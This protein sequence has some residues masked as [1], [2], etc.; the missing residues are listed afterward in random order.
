MRIHD[1]FHPYFDDVKECC[2]ELWCLFFGD[3]EKET[4]E[5]VSHDEMCKVLQRTLHGVT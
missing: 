3:M 1:Y 2:C 5:D 4:R